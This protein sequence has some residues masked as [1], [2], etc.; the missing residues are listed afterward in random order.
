M[1]EPPEFHVACTQCNYSNTTNA[2]SAKY[3]EVVYQPCKDIRGQLDHNMK[4]QIICV[5][6][7]NRFDFYWCAG[8]TIKE[9]DTF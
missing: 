8:H 7:H 9:N 2:P 6:C 5:S 4:G 3:I 1:D